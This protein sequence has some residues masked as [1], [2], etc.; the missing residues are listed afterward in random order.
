MKLAYENFSTIIETS[1]QT[2]TGI[3][4]ENPSMLFRFLADMRE[5]VEGQVEKIVLSSDNKIVDFS[6]NVELLTDFIRFDLNQKAL[7]SKIMTSIDQISQ[8]DKFYDKSQQILAR[9]ESHIMELTIDFPCEFAYEKLNMLSVIK[10]MGISLTDD[11]FCLEEKLLA[12]MDM[13]RD[14]LNKKLFILVNC[15]GFIPCHQMQDFVN[16]ALQ[17]EHEI[18]FVDNMSYPRLLQEKRLIIDE[19]LCEI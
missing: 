19:D 2:V 1:P 8:S 14:F 10:A 6:K 16:T 18:L 7:L 5:T 11:Y 9:I 15:R 12:Y 17:R 4:I 13:V 3:I